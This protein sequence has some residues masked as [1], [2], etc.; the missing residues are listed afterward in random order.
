MVVTVLKTHF[1]KAEPKEIIYRSYKNFNKKTFETE[2]K[3]QLSN[4]KDITYKNLENIFLKTLEHHAPLK[5]KIVRA[6]NVPYMTKI[7]RKEIIRRYALENQF[8]KNST[9][10]HKNY[11]SKLYKKERKKYYTN[12]NHNNIT[13]SKIFGKM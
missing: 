2:L 9:V 5:K 8:Y 7:L 6:N 1:S 13:D 10:Q 4:M 3:K 11:C 12:L